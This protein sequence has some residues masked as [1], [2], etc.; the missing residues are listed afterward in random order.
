MDMTF[1]HALNGIAGRVGWLDAV[2]K[3]GATDLPV[4]LVV[5]I[6]ATWFWPGSRTD[7]D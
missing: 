7:R 3:A 4:V 6:A 5:V 1:Y 2:L